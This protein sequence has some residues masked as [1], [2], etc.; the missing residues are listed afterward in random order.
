MLNI[1]ETEKESSA[2]IAE[3]AVL[4]FAEESELSGLSDKELADISKQRADELYS[5]SYLALGQMRMG[6]E[7]L[8][9]QIRESIKKGDGEVWLT[10]LEYLADGQ[11][12]ARAL[13]QF[14]TSAEAR[15]MVALAT[16]G[17]QGPPR[18]LTAVAKMSPS[19]WPQSLSAAI[20]FRRPGPPERLRWQTQPRSLWPGFF[21]PRRVLLQSLFS[22]PAQPFF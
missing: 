9:D 7:K 1:V 3:M 18:V 2:T 16:V 6:K 12:T 13:L 4:N 11:E 19:R 5:L 8:V 22:L 15:L 20:S 17:E 21:L 14:L 10:M